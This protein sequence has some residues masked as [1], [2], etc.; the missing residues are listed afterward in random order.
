MITDRD[1]VLVEFT[2]D[3]L[4]KAMRVAAE[5]EAN[6]LPTFVG[7]SARIVGTLGEIAFNKTYPDAERRNESNYDF[8]LA[9]RRTEIKSHVCNTRPSASWEV[10]PNKNSQWP[11]Y[12]VFCFV[13]SSFEYG[14]IAGYVSVTDFHNKSVKVL[15]GDP[16]PNGGV[17]KSDGYRFLVKDLMPITRGKR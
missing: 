12:F 3:E 6:G 16:R 2:K 8:L 10:A 15:A 14:W 11:D 5:M 13:H 7:E 9:G 1:F 17:Y 4:S